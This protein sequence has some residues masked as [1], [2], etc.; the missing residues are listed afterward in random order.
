MHATVL[1]APR[2]PLVMRER[3]LPGPGPGEILL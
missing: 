1:D 2:T 3:P